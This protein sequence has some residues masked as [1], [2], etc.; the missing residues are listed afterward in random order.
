[1]NLLTMSRMTQEA[2]VGAILLMKSEEEGINQGLLLESESNIRETVASDPT[3]SGKKN[4]RKTTSPY[5]PNHI[6]ELGKAE[7]ILTSR[8]SP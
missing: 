4:Q 5:F 1:M 6:R 2:K 8:P 3:I 7:R